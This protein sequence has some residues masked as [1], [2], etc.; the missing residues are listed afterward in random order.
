VNNSSAEYT[1]QEGLTLQKAIAMAG[2]VADQGAANR[3][4]ISRKDP[5]TNKFVDAKLDKDRMSTPIQPDDV[6][7]VPA[8]RM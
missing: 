4:T 6:I 1:W 8:K 5:K 7:K 2:G 3:I